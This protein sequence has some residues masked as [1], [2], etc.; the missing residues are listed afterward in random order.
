MRQRSPS[1]LF[2]GAAWFPPLGGVAFLL[3]FYV[4]LPSFR[5]SLDGLYDSSWTV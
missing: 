3:S 1:L 4:V 5:P 2:G